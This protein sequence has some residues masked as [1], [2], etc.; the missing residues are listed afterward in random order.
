MSWFAQ[1]TDH[2][3]GPAAVRNVL[4][5]LGGPVPDEAW[6]AARLGTDANGTRPWRLADR[7]RGLGL[8]VACHTGL[9]VAGLRRALDAGQVPVV[10]CMLPD[11]GVDHYAVVRQATRRQ[12]ALADP[13]RGHHHIPT[14]RFLADW[15]SMDGDL[16]GWGV[17]MGRPAGTGTGLPRRY[18]S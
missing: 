10:L 12:V 9:G 3:C 13:W 5:A 14:G 2:T 15:R 16:Q 7:C 11:E 17:F 8:E 1:E 4:A 18:A 6:L